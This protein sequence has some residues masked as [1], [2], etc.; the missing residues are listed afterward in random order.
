[1][2]RVRE[3][4]CA[5]AHN[6]RMGLTVRGELSG[7]LRT[8]RRGA[9]IARSLHH[10][11]VRSGEPCSTW[12]GEPPGPPPRRR[13]PNGPGRAC[14]LAATSFHDFSVIAFS[15]QD[16]PWALKNKPPQ[17]TVRHASARPRLQKVLETGRVEHQTLEA[18]DLLRGLFAGDGGGARTS[19]CRACKQQPMAT[20]MLFLLK[21]IVS[22]A[23]CG[24]VLSWGRWSMPRPALRR[25]QTGAKKGDGQWKIAGFIA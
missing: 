19:G 1:M 5:G 20:L 13:E 3:A 18:C 25:P 9:R 24:P 23:L 6:C 21:T 14:D 16:A 2:Q 10:R 15:V 7:H 17:S 11:S 4:S 22:H 8:A 12:R